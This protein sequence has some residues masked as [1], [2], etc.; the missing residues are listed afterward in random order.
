MSKTAVVLGAGVTGLSVAWKLSERGW[1]VHIVESRPDIGGMSSCFEWKGMRLDYGPHKMYSQLPVFSEVMSLFNEEELNRIP[2]KS[3]IRLLDKFFDYPL[4]TQ[5]LLV[6]VNPV[7]S[8]EFVMSYGMATARNMVASKE[9]TNYETYMINRFGNSIYSAVFGPYAA[10]AWGD[11]QKLDKSLAESRIAVPSL[12][13]MLKRMVI[14]NKGQP[15]L[16]ASEFHYPKK[17]VDEISRKMLAKSKNVKLHLSS[18][19]KKIKFDNHRI[20]SLEVESGGNAETLNA[21]FVISTIP[22][23]SLSRLFNDIPESVSESLDN[24]NLR[25]LMLVMI[26]AGK[27]RLFTD[28]W[29]FFPESKYI[30]NRISEQKG[31]SHSMVGDGKTVLCVEVTTDENSHILKMSDEQVMSECLVGLNDCGIMGNDDVKDY[32]VVRMGN[33]YPVYSIGYKD[34]LYNVL[35]HIESHGNIVSIGRQ[36]MFSYTGMM[37]CIDMGFKT[38]EFVDSGKPIADWVKVRTGFENYVTID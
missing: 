26:E 3:R 22:L 10:K 1:D 24:L 21:D 13:E 37:D 14:G 11:P 5:Q 32:K 31:F 15:E 18:K 38:A 6:K 4:K 17:G 7:K 2:K 35:R 9:D 25:R 36:G 20:S 30:F 12:L 34:H 19:V 27:E 16:S 23:K 8:S 28:N 33:A 29:I